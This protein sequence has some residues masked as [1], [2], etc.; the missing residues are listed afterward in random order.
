MEVIRSFG[1]DDDRY[2]CR[3]NKGS[4]FEVVAGMY[5][6]T[7]FGGIESRLPEGERDIYVEGLVVGIAVKT[8]DGEKKFPL[9]SHE[10]TEEF[11]SWLVSLQWEFGK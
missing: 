2:Y 3:T 11:E 6:L 10:R 8:Q 1:R 4:L 7:G 5:R 9:A